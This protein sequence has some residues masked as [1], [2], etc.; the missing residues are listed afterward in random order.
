MICFKCGK[1]LSEDAKFC[2]F[3]GARIDISEKDGEFIPETAAI[4]PESPEIHTTPEIPDVPAIPESPVPNDERFVVEIPEEPSIVNIEEKST[5][6]LS[7]K[8]KG[9]VKR[10]PE[11]AKSIWTRILEAAKKLG[12]VKLISIGAGAAVIIVGAVFALNYA[13]NRAGFIHAF[14]GDKKYALSMMSRDAFGSTA[15]AALSGNSALTSIVPADG[16]TLNLNLETNLPVSENEEMNANL[17]AL[18][19]ITAVLGLKPDGE[20]LLGMAQITE[21]GSEIARA[22]MLLTDGR[23]YFLAPD[24]KPLYTETDYNPTSVDNSPSLSEISDKAEFAFGSPDIGGFNGKMMTV[25]LRGQAIKELM[26]VDFA[27]SAVFTVK[28]YINN[29]NTLAGSRYTLTTDTDETELFRLDNPKS[30][31][32]MSAKRG[33]SELKMLQEKASDTAGR[34]VITRNSGSSR[35]FVVDYTDFERKNL[36][37]KDLILGKFTCANLGGELRIGKAVPDSIALELRDDGGSLGITV[38]VS[39]GDAALSANVK[40]T[41]GYTPAEIDIS[42]AQDTKSLESADWDRLFTTVTEHYLPVWKSSRF[43]N[44][45]T[46]DNQRLMDI[47]ESRY[48]IINRERLVKENYAGFNADTLAESNNYA[49]RIFLTA[50]VYS[51]EITLYN[52]IP[53]IV[54]LY[55]DKNG[56][57]SVIENN[58]MSDN[59]IDIISEMDMKSAYIEITLQKGQKNNGL[60]GVTVIR[61]DDKSKIPPALPDVFNYLDTEFSWGDEDSVGYIGAFAAGVYPKLNN[62]ASGKGGEAEVAYNQ[63]SAS[64]AEYDE[65]AEKTLK[66]FNEFISDNNIS[67]DFGGNRAILFSVNTNGDWNLSMTMHWLLGS[68]YALEEHMSAQIH[69]VKNKYVYVY[70]DKQGNAVAASV[71]DNDTVLSVPMFTI[72]EVTWWSICEGNRDGEIIGTYPKLRGFGGTFSEDV[73]SALKGE[74]TQGNSSVVIGDDDLAHIK[75]ITPNSGYVGI[76]L[77]DN[78]TYLFDL[79]GIMI[80]YDMKIYRKN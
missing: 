33:D 77:A 63:L 59:L 34:L 20:D 3:C 41:S 56:N 13:F 2:D 29:D 8:I 40:I 66:A 14:S 65:I 43:V 76:T 37:G 4:I 12:K 9:L 71:S 52:P 17:A 49:R 26:T 57:F 44:T 55:F 47:I 45:A 7:D 36:L 69:D 38:N 19:S 28:Y 22:D 74:W 1:E 10:V 35:T 61:T 80:S 23:L 5:P 75:S 58:S 42:A 27:E 79:D 21:N 73:K 78:R 39:S 15:I 32:S 60:C 51:N 64:V 11:L 67:I 18:K 48:N 62:A 31:F 24:I 16:V 25:I 30:G 70:I 6:A 53:N 72:G 46:S 68:E 50:S 54:K